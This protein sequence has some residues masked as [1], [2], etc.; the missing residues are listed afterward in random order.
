MD[1]KN[2]AIKTRVDELQLIIKESQKELE[3][4]QEN[5]CDHPEVKEVDYM[6][7][8]ASTIKA[9]LCL[10][11][12]KIVSTAFSRQFDEEVKRQRPEGK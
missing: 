4:I 8:P 1:S 3:N 2:L 5:E 10:V 12:N 9:D 11:C 7:R 6:W